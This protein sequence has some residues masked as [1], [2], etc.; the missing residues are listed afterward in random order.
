MINIAKSTRRTI[1]CA[2]LCGVLGAAMGTNAAQAE[3]RLRIAGQHAPDHNATLVLKEIERQLEDANV[4]LKVQLFPAGQLGTGE[5]V[6]GDVQKGAIDIA[7]TFIYSHNDPLLD[8]NS[9]PYL[10][11]SYDEMKTVFSPGSNFYEVYSG[12]LEK[13]GI[14]L[15]GIFGEGFI[16]VGSS[17]EPKDAKGVGDKGLTIRVWSATVA[18]ETAADLGF[19]STTIDWGDVYPALQQGVVDGVIGGT[20]EANYTNFR[21]AINFFVPYNTFVENTAYYMSQDTWDKLDEAQ[22]KAVT[23]I[24]AAAAA[25]S[26][27][28]SEATDREYMQKLSDDGINVIALT[29]EE[30]ADIATHIR[31]KTWPKLEELYGAD[32]LTKLKEDVQ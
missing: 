25:R 26:F 14:R 11:S 20:P 19:K 2:A 1:L 17:K 27:E 30:R 18:K 28:T 23:D 31:N 15:L 3:T 22:Q 6:F 32:L 4:G 29:D 24:F 9:I 13:Q 8:I 5:Q 12:L 10:V 16:G 7:H 21:D